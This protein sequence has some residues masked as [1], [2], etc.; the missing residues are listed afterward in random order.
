ITTNSKAS[1]PAKPPGER[2]V[3]QRGCRWQ[4][5][6]GKEGSEQEGKRKRIIAACTAEGKPEAAKG[7]HQAER[8]KGREEGE[9][10]EGNKKS[11]HIHVTVQSKQVKGLPGR[12]LRQVPEA[13]RHQECGGSSGI[14]HFL[15]WLLLLQLLLGT[16]EDL[17]RKHFLYS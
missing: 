1:T 17:I 14:C 10:G 3:R 5:A 2:E 11:L 15:S 9:E 13:S 8:S 4:A 12:A 16:Q 7:S 6:L